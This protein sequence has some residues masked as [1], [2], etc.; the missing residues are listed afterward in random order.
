MKQSGS[1][2]S[3]LRGVSQQPPEVRQSGQHWEQVNLLPH[4]VSGLTRR[5]GT[6]YKNKQ[7]VGT[8]TAGQ[9]LAMLASA[10][11][12]RKVEHT[13]EGKDYVLL[14]R[15]TL[16]DASYGTGGYVA[17]PS[18]ICYNITDNVF[19]PLASDAATLARAQSIG[20]TGVGAIVSI[21]K[22]IV[23]ALK[24][25]SI[26]ATTT[27]K[28]STATAT[29]IIWVRGGA[30]DRL[31]EVKVVGLPDF[32]YTTPAATVHGSGTAISPQNIAEQLRLSAVASGYTVVR[33]G[34]H[35][36]LTAMPG[37]VPTAECTATDGGDGGNIRAI[38]R[39]TDSADK[40]PIMGIAGQ[41]VQIQTGPDDN[42]YL[43]AIAKNTVPGALDE[44]IWRECAGVIQGG[45]VSLGLM[46]VEGAHCG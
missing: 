2:T 6:L 18:V 30:Y 28:W 44:V 33:N 41:V 46:L 32:S 39:T 25:A 27:D 19:V 24:G 38:C 37:A 20:Q 34:A 26:T 15:E 10:G 35:L 4:P 45:N 22:Y 7:G 3:L 1:W 5:R 12:Y 31:Y 29:P 16:A 21:G 40:L 42:Y 36:A 23:H 9:A 17:T 8:P 13:S 14:V 11:G 43:E